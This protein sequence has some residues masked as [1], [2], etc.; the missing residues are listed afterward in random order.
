MGFPSQRYSGLHSCKI[1]FSTDNSP[2]LI[3]KRNDDIKEH[4]LSKRQAVSLFQ[5]DSTYSSSK[6]NPSVSNKNIFFNNPSEKYYTRNR[7]MEKIDVSDD[8]E[9]RVVYASP[10]TTGGGSRQSNK[11]KKIPSIDI[12]GAPIIYSSPTQEHSRI[13][14]SSNKHETILSVDTNNGQYNHPEYYTEKNYGRSSKSGVIG[15]IAAKRRSDNVQHS[16]PKKPSISTMIKSAEEDDYIYEQAP[17]Y[18]VEEE[19]THQSSGKAKQVTIEQLHKPTATYQ[20][21]HSQSSAPIMTSDMVNVFLSKQN[22]WQTKLMAELQSTLS[23]CCAECKTKTIDMLGER[24]KTIQSGIAAELAQKY[25]QMT[26][27]LNTPFEHSKSHKIPHY[28]PAP[29][30]HHHQPSSKRD[31]VVELML[32]DKLYDNFKKIVFKI[33][34][35]K[36]SAD[37]DKDN[38]ANSVQDKVKDLEKVMNEITAKDDNIDKK[39]EENVEEKMDVEK[40]VDE[41]IDDKI[42]GKPEDADENEKTDKDMPN[43]SSSELEAS[44]ILRVQRAVEEVPNKVVE[45]QSEAESAIVAS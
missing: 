32:N 20:H 37:Y 33:S 27:T 24:L 28:V 6:K 3:G 40:I 13:G 8:I 12:V 16:K 26:G 21:S 23:N 38:A 14:S 34:N 10:T 4:R 44:E 22:D 41:E 15:E 35:T 5:P 39:E 29:S 31:E 45:V 1:S 30:A 7:N 19:Y 43:L 11:Y 42:D 18:T 2:P 9:P 36:R 25:I 17:S